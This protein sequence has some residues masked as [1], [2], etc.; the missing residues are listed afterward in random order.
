MFG[1]SRGQTDTPTD[2]RDDTQTHRLQTPLKHNPLCQHGLSTDIKSIN[3]C[4]RAVSGS[5]TSCGYVS[6]EAR[7][8]TWQFFN[9]TTL[10]CL[11]STD[12]LVGAWHCWPLP[13]LN[14][15]HWIINVKKNLNNLKPSINFINWDR[16][17]NTQFHSSCVDAINFCRFICVMNDGPYTLFWNGRFLHLYLHFFTIFYTI[18][19]FQTKFR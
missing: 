8:E 10:L 13:L 11:S 6:V 7:R 5:V 15:D 2:T 1:L 3:I 19:N 9:S 14:I 17:Y 12:H 16:G 4:R 18:S